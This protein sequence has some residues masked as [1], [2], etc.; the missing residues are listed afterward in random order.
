MLGCA[1][2][3]WDGKHKSGDE[4]WDTWA[5]VRKGDVCFR[6]VLVFGVFGGGGEVE[7]FFCGVVGGIR[8]A[9]S[10]DGVDGGSRCRGFGEQG[11][12]I[13]EIFLEFAELAVVGLR[14]GGVVDAE[15]EL[16]LFLAEFALEDLAGAGDGV[17][18]V[19]EEGF[20]AEGHF[21]V[22]AAIEA[23]ASSAFVGFKL[24]K[25][26]L[27]ETEHVG[28]DLAEPGYLADAE[29]ELVRNL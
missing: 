19:V 24:G 3:D 21:D 11:E 29:V 12:K 2:P 16:R 28:G 27:P 4:D 23:L 14:G 6:G 26:A 5:L 1:V 22:A 17:A 13:A 8:G 25:F 7:E 15:G 10:A 20:D 9:G 18:L